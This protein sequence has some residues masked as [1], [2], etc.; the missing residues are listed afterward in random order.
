MLIVIIFFLNNIFSITPRP[1]IGVLT[2]PY[3]H[4]ESLQKNSSYIAASYVKYVENSGAD[5]IPIFYDYPENKL[6]LIFEKINGLV[7]PGGSE[8]LFLKNPIVKKTK[9]T[10]TTEYLTK[11][12]LEANFRGDFFPVWGT[13][14]GFESLVYALSKNPDILIHFNSVNHSE[15]LFPT[16]SFRNSK[17]FSLIA[18]NKL[19]RQQIEERKAFFFNHNWGLR[20]D[21]FKS[22]QYLSTFFDVTSYSVD[23]NNDLFVASI[24]GKKFPFYGFQ[25]HPEKAMF[26]NKAK[27]DINHDLLTCRAAKSLMDVFVNL[28]N[29]NNHKV[30]NK[31]ELIGL[32]ID[33]YQLV[34]TKGDVYEEIYFFPAV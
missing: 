8:E 15:K 16:D 24:E 23:R 17:A 10:K 33:N 11:L 25:F 4:Q 20:R 3:H 1:L 2:H 28:T 32:L 22:N 6:Q 31:K 14:L 19:L 30:N 26:E 5:V 21:D 29:K 27:E 18:K 13:C 34:R 12:A 9:L 7:L